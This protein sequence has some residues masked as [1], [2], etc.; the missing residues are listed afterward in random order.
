MRRLSALLATPAGRVAR[1][2]VS[3]ALILWL[4]LQIDRGQLR[5]LRGEFSWPAV[6]AALVFF[7]VTFPLQAWRWWLL[8]RA[9][10]I[11]L[12]F[13][14]AHV[15]T[16][17]GQFYNSFLLGGIGGDA[18][19]AYYVIRDAPDR[20]AAG[21]TTLLIDRVAGLIVLMAIAAVALAVRPPA[22]TAA[23]GLRWLFLAAVA[24][25][26]GGAL[27]AAVLLKLSPHRWPA[28]LRRA[29]GP[30]RLAKAAE[31]LA[32]VRASP[33]AHAAALVLGIGIWLL[34]FVAAWLLARAVGLPLPFLET[35]VAMSVAYAVTVL[36]IS[37]GGHGV[38]EGAMLATLAAY[39]LLA[40]D[41][42]R[43]RAFVFALLIWTTTVLWSLVGGLV[44]L[45]APRLLPVAKTPAS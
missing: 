35:C 15:V 16:W 32:A 38:R 3:A 18:A 10:R 30:G 37:V 14:W 19:R 45:A 22:P 4:I 44:A 17:I 12:S 43:D 31:L 8:L 24:T 33:G 27:A 25:T 39:G 42:D 5:A 9:Q 6:L 41:A 20:R 40:A 21:L 7:G 28:P 2:L 13:H 36:P 26:L 1:Y 23:P 34:D 29:L 11:P